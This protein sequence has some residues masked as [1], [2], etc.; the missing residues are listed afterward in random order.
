MI[1]AEAISDPLGPSYCRRWWASVLSWSSRFR[2]RTMTY[3]RRASSLVDRETRK[4]VDTPSQA[5]ETTG[6]TGNVEKVTAGKQRQHKGRCGQWNNEITCGAGGIVHSAQVTALTNTD[7]TETT[8]HQKEV[9]WRHSAFRLLTWSMI[10]PGIFS[11]VNQTRVTRQQRPLATQR[12][13]AFCLLT[14]TIPSSFT[15]L[16]L[17]EKLQRA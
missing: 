3:L 11:A 13:E 12:H 7:K 1:P 9:K 15:A 5:T 4:D 2:V 17:T 8:C 10:M 16:S 14:M 6:S